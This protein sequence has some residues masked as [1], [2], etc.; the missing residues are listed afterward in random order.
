MKLPKDPQKAKI[1]RL[2]GCMAFYLFFCFCYGVVLGADSRGY[3]EMISA[4]E[5]VYPIL[6]WIFRSI[7]GTGFYLNVVVFVQSLLMG[8]AVWYSTERLAKRFVKSVPVFA[9]MYA[10]HA[11]V[12]VLC[13]YASERGSVYSGNIMTEGITISLWLIALTMIIEQ[14]AEPDLGKLCL[15]LILLAVMTDTRKQMAVGY[16]ALFGAMVLGRIGKEAPRM[17]FRRL[18]L[19]FAGIVLS[20]LLALC[21]TRLYNLVLRGNFAQNTRDM[22]LV[23]TT[24]LYVADPEDEKLIG[25]EAVRELFRRTMKILDESES[26]YRYAGAGWSALELHYEEHFDVITVDTTGPLFIEYAQELG[27]A[28]GMEAEQEA[29]R[30]SAVI[31]K[32]L[33]A[34]NLG[35]YL[36]VYCASFLNGIVNTVAKRGGIFD[37]Y[38]LLACLAEAALIV[39]CFLKKESREAARGGMC[40]M[41]AMFANTGVAAALIFC[42]GRYMIYNMPFFYMAGLWLLENL[43]RGRRNESST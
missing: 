35:Q 21:G 9:G 30:M 36:R 1:A 32:S 40:V 7:F 29:D 34:D 11:G 19:L 26:N 3:I 27:F 15:L 17:Y 18:A 39:L 6:L 16:P 5:P 20:V 13:Q 37:L 41:L 31:V 22:N 12:A 8:F 42:Q 25:E 28:E 38:A 33:F 43:I 10:V 24:S 4:R 2:I 14:V 23:L